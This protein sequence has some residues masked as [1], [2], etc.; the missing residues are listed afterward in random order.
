MRNRVYLSLG[1]NTGDRAGNLHAAIERLS[2][3]GE[4]AA[5]SSFYET[6]PLEFTA[7]PWFLNCVVSLETAKT[8]AQV[9][10]DALAIEQQMGRRRTQP[11][12][13]RNIDID[14]LLYGDQIVDE[15]LAHSA[16]CAGRAEI[17]TG[18]AGG[19]RPGRAAPGTEKDFVGIAERAA[20]R[21]ARPQTSA[22]SE[23]FR[24]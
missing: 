15:G 21:A 11:K 3:I 22:G 24:E 7:Q 6:E 20:A 19:D 9:L 18:A 1:S 13:P 4:V 2:Q 16:P 12:G 23:K 10:Q 8:P 17:C 5:I 14:V